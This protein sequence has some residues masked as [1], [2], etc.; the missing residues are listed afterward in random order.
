MNTSSR[1]TSAAVNELRYGDL[2]TLDGA[3]ELT[4]TMWA[5]PEAVAGRLFGKYSAG[6]W[7]FLWYHWGVPTRTTLLVTD[8]SNQEEWLSPAAYD[9]VNIYK[10]NFLSVSWKAGTPSTC[11]MYV[12]D[13]EFTPTKGAPNIT[14][15]ANSTV[16]FA[17]FGSNAAS[18]NY[19][20]RAAN[21]HV[22]DRQLSAA[23]I[24]SVKA[25]PK[26]VTTNL[27]HYFALDDSPDWSDSWGS[28]GNATVV[29]TVSAELD[30]PYRNRGASTLYK[31]VPMVRAQL[32]R[33]SVV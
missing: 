2:T 4:F 26:A 21:I 19:F 32:D 18:T 7:S 30:G 9:A 31:A 13:T 17:L 22:Y 28:A 16:D 15:I 23:E 8:G 27:V 14:S 20:G 24:A 10:W 3:T 29:G 1:T 12:N 6:S 11:K 25:T 33:K 5:R